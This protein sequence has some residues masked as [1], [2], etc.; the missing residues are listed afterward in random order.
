[1]NTAADWSEHILNN[2]I[3]TVL[4]SEDFTILRPEDTFTSNNSVTSEL[5]DERD[6]FNVSGNKTLIRT[7]MTSDSSLISSSCK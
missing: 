1:M 3:R 2:W 5:F 7:L 4:W 6:I